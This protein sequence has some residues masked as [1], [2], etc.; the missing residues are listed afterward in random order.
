MKKRK[1]SNYAIVSIV[2]FLLLITACSTESKLNG[3]W[4][5]INDPEMV[6]EFFSDG[7]GRMFNP[8][9]S[10]SAQI[11]YT[12]LNDGKRIQMTLYG[13]KGEVQDLSFS[14]GRLKIGTATYKKYKR[15]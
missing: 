3:R 6:I 8:K 4:Q 10:E 5:N 9:G 12:L 2:A 14:G 1:L 11:Q 7:T 15:N 13:F